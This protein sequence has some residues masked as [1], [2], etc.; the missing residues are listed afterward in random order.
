MAQPTN[1]FSSYDQVGVREDLTD[2]IHDVSPTDTPFYSSA[3]KTTASNT[4]HEWQTDAIRASA[5]NAHIEGDDTVATA[6]T[7][8]VRLGNYS[9]IFK[10]AVITTGTDEGLNKAGRGGEMEYQLIKTGRE[11]RLD[12]ERALLDNNARVAG[13][14]T[15]ARE[16]AGV[17]SW[18]VTN[19]VAAGADPTGDGTDTRT[20]A[21][22]VAFSQGR[23]DTCLQSIWENSNGTND[24]TVMLSAY[25]MNI[26]L[27]F[28]G[29][30][31]QRATIPANSNKVVNVVDVYMTPWG[32]VDFVMS[33]EMRPRDVLAL[34]LSMFKIAVLRGFETEPL[35]KTGDNEKRQVVT[36]LTLESCNEKASGGV[37]DNTTA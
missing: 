28:T 37:F 17:P 4:Y 18:L 24:M 5:V 23:M 1:T 21:A 30:N 26:A 14:D 6:R 7:P 29:N 35:A 32:S 36:E 27:G 15:V 9:Q 20:D 3:G 33:R 2:I 22:Q 34:D 31:N 10:D 19:T 13:S 12:I 11:I 25:Q 16:L 8:T